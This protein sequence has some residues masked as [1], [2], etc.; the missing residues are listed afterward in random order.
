M[1]EPRWIDYIL[2]HPYHNPDDPD[3]TWNWDF[4]SLNPNIS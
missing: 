1:A 4:I 3:N 2:T